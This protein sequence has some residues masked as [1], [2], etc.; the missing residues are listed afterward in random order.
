MLEQES[1][2]GVTSNPAILERSILGSADYDA[3]VQRLADEAHDTEARSSRPI[4]T[5]SWSTAR[6]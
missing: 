2:R 1:L 6:T 5:G 4:C 3:D